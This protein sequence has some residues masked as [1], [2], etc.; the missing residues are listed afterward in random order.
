MGQAERSL[1]MKKLAL[2]FVAVLAVAALAAPA[3]ACD[4]MK[5]TTVTTASKKPAV[6]S[7]GNATQEKGS[8]KAKPTSDT[9]PA[10]APN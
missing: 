9:K 7:K 5:N 3:F 8:A 2:R 6:A 1:D 10:T 4:Y